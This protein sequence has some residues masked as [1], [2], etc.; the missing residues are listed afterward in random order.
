VRCLRHCRMETVSA[1]RFRWLHDQEE[2]FTAKGVLVLRC[3]ERGLASKLVDESYADHKLFPR[4]SKTEASSWC[5]RTHIFHFLPPTLALV[6]IMQDDVSR[7][8][9][10][11]A[12]ALT[13]RHG[14]PSRKHE[15]TETMVPTTSRLESIQVS[16][17]NIASSLRQYKCLHILP[18]SACTESILSLPLA[19]QLS[20]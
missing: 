1:M 3:L 19:V 12:L 11:A 4:N 13:P 7:R 16:S 17:H 15:T 10:L 6:L 2:S 9:L 14:T 18:P 8:L 20:F 5:D